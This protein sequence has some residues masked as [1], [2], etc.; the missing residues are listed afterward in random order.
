M[1]G[2]ARLYGGLFIHERGAFVVSMWSWVVELVY[3]CTELARGQFIFSENIVALA[4][5]PLMLGW[6]LA[7][8]RQTFRA[9]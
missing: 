8:Y 6:S 2:L 3:T 7:Y 5:A 1:L 4:L 9:N